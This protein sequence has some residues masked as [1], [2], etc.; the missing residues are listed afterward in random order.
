MNTNQGKNNLPKPRTNSRT[1][2]LLIILSIIV[3]GIST[4]QMYTGARKSSLNY[5][6]IGLSLI[7]ILASVINLFRHSRKK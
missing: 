7:V 3:I 1:W 2:I 6:T 5:L 4:Y